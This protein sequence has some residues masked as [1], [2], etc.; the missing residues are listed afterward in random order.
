MIDLS[1]LFG[2]EDTDGTLPCTF[3]IF[4][5]VGAG[6]WM[7]ETTQRRPWHLKTW[8]RANLRARVIYRVAWVLGVFGIYLPSR[9]ETYSVDQGSAYA[10]IREA[11]DHLGI[12]LGTPGPNRKIVVYAARPGRSVFVKI[13]LSPISATLVAKEAAALE[14]LAQDA[15]LGHLVPSA[16]QIAG[17][18]AVENI[19][20]G[21]VTHTALDLLE[22]TRIHNLLERR[23]TTTLPLSELRH[24]WQNGYEGIILSHE[25][26]IVN[27]VHATRKAATDLLD[28]LPQDLAVPCYLAHGDF[29]RW[30]V[31]RAAD[32]TARIIDWEFYGLKPRWFDLVHYVVSHDMLVEQLS[33]IEIVAHLGHVAK[34]V[35]IAASEH[36]WWR[37]V[38]LYFANQALHYCGVYERQVNLHE[39][40]IWQ[41]DAWSEV[42][43]LLISDER[44]DTDKV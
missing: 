21:G 32:G 5:K 27:A 26:T 23:S 4:P 15:D 18:L 13:P 22:V 33:P 19:E 39:Q 20:I 10:Q 25:A 40:A 37:Q 29:T 35:G 8:P 38:G 16:G 43:S 30:N 6:R 11:Y 9:L 31:L 44:P 1:P 34:Q 17:H 28:T 42:L 24:N 41:L 36:N 3:R 14:E 12:F 7:L 2:P